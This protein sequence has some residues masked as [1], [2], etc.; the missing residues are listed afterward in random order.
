MLAGDGQKY[1]I[2]IGN[3]SK[4]EDAEIITK[5]LEEFNSLDEAELKAKYRELIK[6]SRISEKGGAGLGLIDI[7]KKTKNKIDYQSTPLDSD[8]SF[9]I[10]QSSVN[11]S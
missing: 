1:Y 8:Y 4:V 9:F 10:Q 2:R 11:I 3:V 6:A 7:I 5:R